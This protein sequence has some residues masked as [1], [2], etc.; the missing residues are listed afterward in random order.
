MAWLYDTARW[1]ELPGGTPGWL[2]AFLLH[3]LAWYVDHRL[4]HR[5]GLLWAMHHVHHSSQEYNM[6]VASRGFLLDESV[7]RP[8]FYLLPVFGV[9]PTQFIVLRIVVS[10]WG[11]AQHTRLVPRLGVLDRWFATP[12][13][14]RVHHGSDPEYIDRNYGEV[15][16]LWDHLFGT[17]T[18]EGRE[19]RYGVTEPINTYNPLEIQLA[20]FRGLR[21]RMASAERWSDKLKYLVMPPEWHHTAAG[22]PLL[23]RAQA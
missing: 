1:V 20:G 8:I 13:S 12:S 4:G 15:L 3:D 11:I 7:A 10:V 23:A 5:V 16:M 21:A 18:P 9:S 22:A 19:P 6:T 2:I 14:H 17:Y